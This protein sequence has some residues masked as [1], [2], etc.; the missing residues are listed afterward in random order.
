MT[1]VIEKE[2]ASIS[3]LLKQAIISGGNVQYSR[4]GKLKLL[5]GHVLSSRSTQA[6]NKAQR[7]S[8]WFEVCLTCTILF[9]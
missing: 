4:W 8:F 3:V 1:P 7:Q 6:K 9:E 2:L 5:N